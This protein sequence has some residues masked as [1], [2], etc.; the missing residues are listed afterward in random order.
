MACSDITEHHTACSISPAGCVVP[1]GLLSRHSAALVLAQIDLHPKVN[2]SA[3][4]CILVGWI[5]L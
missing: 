3:D 5:I 4:G 1:E 2:G